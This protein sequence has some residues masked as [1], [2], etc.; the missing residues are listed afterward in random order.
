MPTL[1]H[2]TAED[3][4]AWLPKFDPIADK[5]MALR[6]SYPVLWQANV[7]RMTENFVDYRANARSDMTMSMFRFAAET[8]TVLDDYDVVVG[9]DEVARSGMS[10]QELAV[11]VTQHSVHCLHYRVNWRLL[12][13][14]IP[15]WLSLWTEGVARYASLRLHDVGHGEALFDPGLAAM[16]PTDIKTAAAQMVPLI[17]VASDALNR[18]YLRAEGDR[19]G[20]LLGLRIV[21]KQ[22]KIRSLTDFIRM[23]GMAARDIVRSELMSLSA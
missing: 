20:L 21:E 11:L 23:P 8:M 17:D 15:L 22:A 16:P 1:V 13:V 2:V 9:L 19:M 5:A 4:A 14:A 6:Q 7:A 18:R 12:P 10:E 3:L